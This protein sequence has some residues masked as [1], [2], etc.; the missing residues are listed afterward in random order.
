MVPIDEGTR[1]SDRAECLRP[2]L[3]SAHMSVSGATAG[4]GWARPQRRPGSTGFRAVR[5]L[6]GSWYGP[7]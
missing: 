2:R 1:R 5:H 4:H 7:V 6:V 3:A